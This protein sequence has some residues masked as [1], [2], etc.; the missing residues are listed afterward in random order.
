MLKIKPNSNDIIKKEMNAQ[1]FKEQLKYSAYTYSTNEQN[2]FSNTFQNVVTKIGLII[3]EISENKKMRGNGFYFNAIN[4]ICNVA[5][6]NR[7]LFKIFKN[8]EINEKSNEN[9]HSLS[10]TANLDLET[11]IM[12]YNKMLELLDEAYN[13]PAILSAKIIID[14]NN[15]LIEKGNEKYLSIQGNKILFYLPKKY[16]YDPYSKTL[17]IKL[18]VDVISST[19]DYIFITVKNMNKV[20]SEFNFKISYEQKIYEKTLILNKQDLVFKNNTVELKLD[21]DVKVKRKQNVNKQ[22]NK[23]GLIFTKTHFY[24]TNEIVQLEN[25]KIKLIKKILL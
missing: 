13:I 11:I 15:Q 4:Y 24:Q 19:N 9:K 20:I 8:I 22:Y 10:R 21:L 6:K 2:I 23:K 3:S 18:V 17:S 1:E 7:T 25:K 12:N 14:K 5:L 16:E